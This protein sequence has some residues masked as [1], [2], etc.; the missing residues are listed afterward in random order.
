VYKKKKSKKITEVR[1]LVM[2]ESER[3]YF[4][5]LL[6]DHRKPYIQECLNFFP[7]VEINAFI[8]TEGDSEIAAYDA[9]KVMIEVKSNRKSNFCAAPKYPFLKNEG[10]YL[11][12]TTGQALVFVEHFNFDKELKEFKFDLRHEKAGI[13]AL[14]IYLLSDCYFGMD[15]ETSVKY[16]VKAARKFTEE[17]EQ[18]ESEEDQS[19]F[20]KMMQQIIP[21]QEEE[22]SDKEDNDEE[23]KKTN[24]GKTEAS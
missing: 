21:T 11:I 1:S 12:A 17:E 2:N 14:S 3:E 20:S 13:F 18:G 24:D 9:F 23:E 8:K 15:I 6:D 10:W 16:E 19:F 4:L 7:K 22:V 5:S